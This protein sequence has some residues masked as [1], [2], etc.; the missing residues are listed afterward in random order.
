MLVELGRSKLKAEWSN[1][2]RITWV[3]IFRSGLRANGNLLWVKRKA[4]GIFRLWS[5]SG[6]RHAFLR[7]ELSKVLLT[8]LLT[9]NKRHQT[10]NPIHTSTDKNLS[11]L[12]QDFVYIYLFVTWTRYILYYWICSAQTVIGKIFTQRFRLF[13]G[14]CR[15]IVYAPTVHSWYLSFGIYQLWHEAFF[16]KLPKFMYSCKLYSAPYTIP[17]FPLWSEGS[18]NSV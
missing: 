17:G 8:V 18:T 2:A 14:Q 15:Y 12:Y 3:S 16:T 6:W 7:A 11:R 13:L 4:K 5:E 10:I 9:R 1:P